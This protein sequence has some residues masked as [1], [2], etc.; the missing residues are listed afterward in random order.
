MRAASGLAL[1][2]LSV[3]PFNVGPADL[4]SRAEDFH[5]A[6]SR[7]SGIKGN[8][9]GG[10]EPGARGRPGGNPKPPQLFPVCRPL[11]RVGRAA[12]KGRRQHLLRGVRAPLA[13][14]SNLQPVSLSPASLRDGIKEISEG[15]CPLKGDTAF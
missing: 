10:P 8:C 12:R 5:S 4:P 2:P 3:C 7:E 15:A 14:S 13:G 9:S 6:A 1:P 11:D